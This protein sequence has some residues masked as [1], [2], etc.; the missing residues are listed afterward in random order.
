VKIANGIGSPMLWGWGRSAVVLFPRDLLPRLSVEARDTLLAHELAHYLR[1]D[2]W[3]RVLEFAATGLYWWHPAVWVARNGIEA[4]EEECCDAWVVGGLAASPRRYAEALLATVDYEAELRRPCLPPGACAANRGAGLIRRRL[5]ALIDAE[6]PRK[7]GRRAAVMWVVVVAA[8]LTRPVL[9]AAAPEIAEPAVEPVA[10][11]FT[12]RAPA[13]PAPRAVPKKPTE[14]RP[15]ATTASPSGGLT[16]IAR[17]NEVILRFLDGTSRTLGPGRPLAV[18][19]EPGGKRLATVG[20]GTLIRTWDDRGEPLASAHTAAAGRALAYTPDGTRLLVLDA[21][22]AI[23]VRDPQTLATVASWY[24]EGTANS[25]A[26][27]PDGRTVAVSF[28]SW[29][30][31]TGSVELWLIAE[32]KKVA[33]YAAPVPVGAARF[34]P[35]GDTLVIGGWNGRV[36]WRS[37]PSGNLIAERDLTKDLVATAAFSP[38][39][40][41][42]TEPPPEPEPPAVPELPAIPIQVPQR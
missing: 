24:V 13:S 28:G 18:A 5:L 37:L 20:P 38:D 15:W 29:L 10:V 12:K 26:P 42:P 19:F 32:R 35:S 41:L 6:P 22:G 33:T 8:L 1:R 40:K 9:R 21:A 39:A 16:V 34:T 30:S 25:I 17:D 4:A 31:E 36:F 27:S 3:V 2:H 14:P 11:E 23:T 7:T